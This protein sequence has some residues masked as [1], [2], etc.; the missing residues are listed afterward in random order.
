MNL[1]N[2]NVYA[3]AYYSGAIYNETIFLLEEDY[4]KIKDDLKQKICLGELDGKHSEVYGEINIDII[5]ETKQLNYQY[6]ILNDDNYLYYELYEI[7]QKKGL[8]IDNMIKKASK[9]IDGLDSLV[10]V[11]YVIKKSQAKQL[12]KWM[13]EK[14]NL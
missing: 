13:S 3:E 4:N 8:K 2:I 5:E 12:K 9:F 6:N 11:K 10:E 1:V 7:A 14:Y